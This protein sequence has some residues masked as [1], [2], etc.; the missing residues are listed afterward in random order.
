M[1]VFSLG[2]EFV[3]KIDLL[4]SSVAINSYNNYNIITGFCDEDLERALYHVKACNPVLRVTARAIVSY[5]KK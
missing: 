5:T 4:S 3:G 1:S 2:E